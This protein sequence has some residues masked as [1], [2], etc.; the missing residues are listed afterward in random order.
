VG[1]DVGGVEVG[2]VDVGVVDV[3]DVE[4]PDVEVPDVEVGPAEGV[5]SIVSLVES[6]RL[7]TCGMGSVTHSAGIMSFT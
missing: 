5:V 3:P 2:A 7:G 1:V 6:A 4:V